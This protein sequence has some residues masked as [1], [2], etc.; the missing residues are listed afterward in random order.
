MRKHLLAQLLLIGAVVSAV[1]VV[2]ALKVPWFPPEAATQARPVDTLYRVLLI[3]S[4]PMFVLVETVVLFSVWR[5]RERPGQEGQDGPPIHGNTR[6]EVLWTAIPAV[7]LLS[8]GGYAYAVLHKI[9]KPR[10][11][12]MHVQVMARQ[13]AWDFT[14]A[15]P[16]GRRVVSPELYLPKDVP[17]RFS[18]RSKDVIHDFGVPAFRIAIDTV[19]GITTH[20]RATPTRLG[21][22]PVMCREL[23][24][25]GHAAMRTTVHV[26]RKAE[27]DQWL[28][29]QAAAAQPAG[30]ES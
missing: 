3:C 26:V 14:Y 19:P 20:V 12:E 2:L 30:G 16:G 6:L 27:F 22:Y 23:C 29:R 28:S 4:V 11:S 5:F 17:V 9:E 1:M 18:V 10:P 13:F 7:L 24:G 15:A 25:L 8:L 21:S